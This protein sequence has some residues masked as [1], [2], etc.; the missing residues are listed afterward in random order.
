MS[1][2]SQRITDTAH[3]QTLN[4]I[5]PKPQCKSESAEPLR[6]ST[7]VEDLSAPHDIVALHINITFADTNISKALSSRHSIGFQF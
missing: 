1:S 7:L 6:C 5:M 2:G 4:L 3:R